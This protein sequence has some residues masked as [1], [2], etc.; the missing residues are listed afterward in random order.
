AER[1]SPLTHVRPGLPPVLTIHG[2]ADP[3]VPYEHAVRLR[4][5]LDRA[6]VPNRLHTVR[7]GGH[8]NFRVEE[9]Q[10]IY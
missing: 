1:V 8:G 9:Y 7:G 6:G 5:S 4:E 2:D 3:T 10:E